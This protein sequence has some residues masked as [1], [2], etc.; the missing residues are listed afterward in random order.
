MRYKVRLSKQFKKDLR[1]LQRSSFDMSKLKEVVF[2][3]EN[4]EILN[5]KLKDHALKGNLKNKRECP[6]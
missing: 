3:L 6:Y 2:Q 1:K 5:P 4:D